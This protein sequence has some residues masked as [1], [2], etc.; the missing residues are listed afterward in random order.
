[1][2]RGS[3][4]AGDVLLD[5]LYTSLGTEPTYDPKAG[6]VYKV[7]VESHQKLYAGLNKAEVDRELRTLSEQVKMF[8]T[9]QETQAAIAETR[10]KSSRVTSQNITKFKTALI[11]ATTELSKSMNA[12]SPAYDKAKLAADNTQGDNTAKFVAKV[13]ALQEWNNAFG[14]PLSASSRDNM[15]TM[16]QLAVEHLGKNLNEVTVDQMVA[17][18][19]TTA[20][21]GS[22]GTWLRNNFGAAKAGYED[23]LSN[24]QMLTEALDKANKYEGKYDSMLTTLG[25]GA[26][27]AKELNNEL[28]NLA[29]QLEPTLMR[30]T[31]RSPADIAAQQELIVNRNKEIEESQA[32]IDRQEARAYGTSRQTADEKIGR[33]MATSQF[34]EWAAGNG[35]KT[36]EYNIDENG[37]LSMFPGNED[38]AALRL[39]LY[40]ANRPDRKYGPLFASKSTGALV[41]VTTQDPAQKAEIMKKY[42]GTD[43]NYYLD[44]KG[45]L[46]R[47][48]EAQAAFENGGYIPSIEGAVVGGEAFLRMPNG[49]VVDAKTGQPA[50]APGN[51][52]FFPVF[53]KDDANKPASFLSP[54]DV[55]DPAAIAELWAGSKLGLDKG[56]L[57]PEDAQAL[58]AHTDRAPYK[59]ADEN[60]VK[61]SWTGV[62]TG[63]LD[64]PHANDAIRGKAGMSTISLDGGKI[65]IPGDQP[66]TIEVVETR[67]PGLIAGV[68]RA[69]Q[70]SM[71]E[72]HLKELSEQGVAVSREDGMPMAERIKLGEEQNERFLAPRPTKAGAGPVP[73]VMTTMTTSAGQQGLVALPADSSALRVAQRTGVPTAP[74]VP[75]APIES[76]VAPTATTPTATTT[77]TPATAP[78]TATPATKPAPGAAPSATKTMKDDKG[79]VFSVTDDKITFVSPGPDQKVPPKTEWVKSSATGT[80]IMGVLNAEA[81]KTPVEAKPTTTLPR[82][83]AATSVTAPAETGP[84]IGSRGAAAVVVPRKVPKTELDRE[85]EKPAF[86]KAVDARREAL[87]VAL[88]KGA[89]GTE[90]SYVPKPVEAG[91]RFKGQDRDLLPGLAAPSR[92]PAMFS[93]L[94]SDKL[95]ESGLRPEEIAQLTALRDRY[96]KVMGLVPPVDQKAPLSGQPSTGRA[97][98]LKAQ[99]LALTEMDA[100]GEATRILEGAKQRKMENVARTREV[101]ERNVESAKAPY[102]EYQQAQADA[103]TIEAGKTERTSRRFAPDASGMVQTPYEA[104]IKEAESRTTPPKPMF[105]KTPTPEEAELAA[106]GTISS[107]RPKPNKASAFSFFKRKPS[108]SAAVSPELDMME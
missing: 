59:V 24:S 54:N 43:G 33:L 39:F 25:A 40:Q 11:D 51:A 57:S 69:F 45:G 36:G 75:G 7:L 42:R 10:G 37:K 62:Y 47:P 81:A 80:A 44:A 87:R 66:S 103:R 85:E 48:S 63:R 12:K 108:M 5:D 72:Q 79:N 8:R 26:A 1:M 49:S 41:R 4:F 102:K 35:F 9:A 84:E 71:P 56:N 29:D 83:G 67:E 61:S 58:Q 28:A 89:R 88:E 16:N 14:K 70:K 100:E 78:A 76:T 38:K 86:R 53:K 52:Q 18:L 106:G 20:A 96:T 101:A 95:P 90:D 17:L 34:K 107:N 98:L 99:R 21:S 2:A 92:L 60:T 55:R 82:A 15:P 91:E 13:A 31:G 32:R 68:V 3:Y 46:V 64:R 93:I 74:I 6:D 50:T 105:D 22:T 104:T 73:D 27:G 19:G 94:D 77:A 23:M 97:D 65:I 30:A